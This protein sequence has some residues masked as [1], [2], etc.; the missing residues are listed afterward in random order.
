MLGLVE[1]MAVRDMLLASG[2]GC[3]WLAMTVLLAAGCWLVMSLTVVSCCTVDERT[4]CCTD[5]VEKL[6]GFGVELKEPVLKQSSNSV[7]TSIALCET[8]PQSPLTL[9][10]SHTLLPIVDL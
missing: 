4:C 8:Y 5:E 7:K 1:G 6:A 2:C 9:E 3:N 10:G